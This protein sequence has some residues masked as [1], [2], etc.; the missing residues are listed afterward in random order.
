MSNNVYLGN[1]FSLNMLDFAGGPLVATFT[2]VNAADVPQSAASVVGHADT[3]NVVAS[4][5]GF[6]VPM[7]RTTLALNVG[8]VLYVA[9]LFGAR[10]PEGTSTLPEGA[11]L[12]F[13]RVDVVRA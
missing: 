10:L 7:N 1:A 2:P 5:L 12:A 6:P 13:V 4:V 11:T 3:A 8:D 9:Q